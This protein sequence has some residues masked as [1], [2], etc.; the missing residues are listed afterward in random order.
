M[1][2]KMQKYVLLAAKSLRRNN[3]ICNALF[4]VFRDAV[5]TTCTYMQFLQFFRS[6]K[7]SYYQYNTKYEYYNYIK[8]KKCLSDGAETV[9][10][11]HY[12][13]YITTV[14]C[15]HHNLY[16]LQHNDN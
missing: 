4:T 12:S 16:G 6:A 5:E 15:P 10:N 14:V 3:Y 9:K 13:R 2:G 11:L 7:I 8:L 1:T